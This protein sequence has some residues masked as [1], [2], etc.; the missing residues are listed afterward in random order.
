M[1]K[2]LSKELRL[3][4]LSRAEVAEKIG[5]TTATLSNWI[6][7]RYPISSGGVKE[8]KKLG[9]SKKAVS[10]PEKEV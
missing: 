1:E 2:Q 5:V 7:G 3:L 9:V 6:Q 10:D 4:G 8:L